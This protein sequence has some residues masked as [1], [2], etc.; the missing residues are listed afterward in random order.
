MQQPNKGREADTTQ[1]VMSGLI[2]TL[3]I[4]R[5]EKKKNIN[6][7]PAVFSSVCSSTELLMEQRPG[8]DNVAIPLA[9]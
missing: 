2:A 8:D 4:Y 3:V 5:E 1:G 9:E 6:T 7:T